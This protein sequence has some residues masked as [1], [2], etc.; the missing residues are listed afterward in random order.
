MFHRKHDNSNGSTVI[1]NDFFLLYTVCSSYKQ[2]IIFSGFYHFFV[3][4]FLDKFWARVTQP[5]RHSHLS[6]HPDPEGVQQVFRKL[7]VE[8]C[9]LF[10]ESL[11]FS[12]KRCLQSD[13]ETKLHRIHSRAQRQN[14][15]QA[16]RRRNKSVTKSRTAVPTTE[17]IPV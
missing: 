8:T 9:Y 2:P 4:G 1:R 17:T 6:S 14:I 16:Q 11:S 7:G 3:D 15:W 5:G 12:F 10:R 13:T